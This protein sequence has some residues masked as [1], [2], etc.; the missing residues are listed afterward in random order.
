VLAKLHF[1]ICFH[2]LVAV[3][4]PLRR[5]IKQVNPYIAV[6]ALGFAGNRTRR[7]VVDKEFDGRVGHRVL[8]EVKTLRVNV[9]KARNGEFENHKQ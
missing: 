6:A 4:F 3:G 5:V 1:Y 9:R 2:A 7:G 8:A